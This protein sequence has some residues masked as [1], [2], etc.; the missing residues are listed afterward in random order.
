MAWKT[1]L[2]FRVRRSEPVVGRDA[3][4]QKP[5]KALAICIAVIGLSRDSSVAP[6]MTAH[7]GP[8]I[9]PQLGGPKRMLLI[10]ACLLMALLP[11][12]IPTIGNFAKFCKFPFSTP[13]GRPMG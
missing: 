1:V 6:C 13:I 9:I 8:Y 4:A 3:M 7:I 5:H 12:T 11:C 2:R 10:Q